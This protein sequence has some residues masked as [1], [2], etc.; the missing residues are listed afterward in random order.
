MQI[1]LTT[2]TPQLI[3]FQYASTPT[4]LFGLIGFQ[5]QAFAPFVVY[6]LL[7]VHAHVQAWPRS[8][9]VCVFPTSATAA[10]Y[11]G[12][13]GF[14]CCSL[15]SDRSCKLLHRWTYLLEVLV[16]PSR[17]DCAL[18][19]IGGLVEDSLVVHAG[20]ELNDALDLRVGLLFQ[21]CSVFHRCR[22][23]IVRCCS[24]CSSLG[25]LN[26]VGAGRLS[27]SSTYFVT[28]VGLFV[29]HFASLLSVLLREVGMCIPPQLVAALLP[30]V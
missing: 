11:F 20:L 3:L 8:V 18:H 25:C 26:G 14:Q 28:I 29:L 19:K 16:G 6:F 1:Y 10:V 27:E 13:E 4:V 2:V 17:C 7:A 5:F 9:P 12:S 23:A 15:S 21:C 22:E 24:G 30:V